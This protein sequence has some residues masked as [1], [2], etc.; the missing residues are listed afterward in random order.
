LLK[1]VIKHIQREP[2]EEIAVE[3]GVPDE[4]ACTLQER[5]KSSGIGVSGTREF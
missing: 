2:I 5:R 4:E 3:E 1:Q